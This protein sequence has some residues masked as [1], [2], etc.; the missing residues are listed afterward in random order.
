M[1]YLKTRKEHNSSVSYDRTTSPLLYTC[2]THTHIRKKCINSEWTWCS[3]IK[4]F[5]IN[6][7][8]IVYI[9]KANEPT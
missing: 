5:Y 6:I 3:Q 9:I 1:P 7:D 4:F 2:T 8:K